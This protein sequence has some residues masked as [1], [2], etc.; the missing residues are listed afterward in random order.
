[1][2]KAKEMRAYARK[3][4]F[5][6]LPLT[7]RSFKMIENVLFP[8]EQVLVA[9]SGSLNNKHVWKW[10]TRYAFALT[11]HRLIYA[12]NKPFSFKTET[13]TIELKSVNDVTFNKDIFR[14]SITFNTLKSTFYIK[15]FAGPGKR[16]FKA[17]NICLGEF[18]KHGGTVTAASAP[19]ASVADELLKYKQLLDSGAITQAEFEQF[20]KKHL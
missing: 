2:K 7:V 18:R 13:Q 19:S 20:K 3:N 15:K 12:Q 6:N 4:R 11:D 1:M 5:R 14:S 10:R 8:D 16:I 9:F 17:I